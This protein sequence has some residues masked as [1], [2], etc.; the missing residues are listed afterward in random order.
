MAVA[1]VSTDIHDKLTS[2]KRQAEYFFHPKHHD[3]NPKEAQW[4]VSREEEFSVFDSAD[5]NDLSDESGNLYGVLVEK[6]GTGFVKIGTKGQQVAFFHW[7]RPGS[8][9]HGY[10]LYP[11][12]GEIQQRKPPNCLYAKME[13][14]S[15]IG[16]RT[17]RR[18]RSA[19]HV[20]RDRLT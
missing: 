17:A 19:R 7:V 18:L 1:N 14:A 20:E 15:L 9:W 12:K 16:P 8:P 11:L 10:P 4:A 2:G 5:A 3:G 6:M 13:A